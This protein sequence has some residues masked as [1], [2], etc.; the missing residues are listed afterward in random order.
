MHERKSRNKS[1][2]NNYLYIIAQLSPKLP[3][4]ARTTNIFL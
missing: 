1:K 3:W 4:A 2:I